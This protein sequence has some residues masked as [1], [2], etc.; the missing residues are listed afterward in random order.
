MPPKRTSN[1]RKHHAITWLPSTQLI[2]E[3]HFLSSVSISCN[4]ASNPNRTKPDLTGTPI[5][6]NG[7]TIKSILASNLSL[8]MT[9]KELLTSFRGWFEG[10]NRIILGTTIA[11]EKQVTIATGTFNDDTLSSGISKRSNLLE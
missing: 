6:K 11:E 10:L 1:I 5:V 9:R 7:E 2:T 4:K 3:W 8:Q